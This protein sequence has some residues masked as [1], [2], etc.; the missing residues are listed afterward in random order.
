MSLLETVRT[1]RIRFNDPRSHRVNPQMV[2]T[3]HPDH[4]QR[5]RFA[6]AFAEGRR[7]LDVGRGAGYG[8]AELAQTADSVVGIDPYG[9]GIEFARRTYPRCEFRHEDVFAHRGEYDLI[10]A[11][12]VIEHV[13]DA[14]GF[15][16]AITKSA[17][18]PLSSI[19]ETLEQA[20][21]QIAVARRP[22]PA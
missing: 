5:Y 13:E 22:G 19:E 17:G 3:C 11:F 10:V 2:A 9:E 12:E 6:R 14:A 16:D 20:F 8:S 1:A 21:V 15:A 7:V 18:E 4:I